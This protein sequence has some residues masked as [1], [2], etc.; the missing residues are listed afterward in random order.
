[1]KLEKFNNKELCKDSIYLHIKTGYRKQLSYTDCIYSIF[2][3]HNETV[4]IWTHLGTSILFMFLFLSNIS[5]NIIANNYLFYA[6]LGFLCSSI[7]HIF[8]CNNIYY[9]I[10]LCIDSTGLFSIIYLSVNSAMS[11][12]LLK[13]VLINYYY[14]YS[15]FYTI[16]IFTAYLFFI[17]KI[18][19][20]NQV[21]HISQSLSVITSICYYYIPLLHLY[22]ICNNQFIIFYNRWNNI[23]F[24]WLFCFFIF[25]LRLPERLI[26][27]KFDYFLNSHNIF[28][29]LVSYCACKHY[30]ILNYI[31]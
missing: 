16:Y 19:E 6:S 9:K 18:I 1:M 7:F 27:Y 20:T 4:N 25:G 2:C 28:H 17:K 3:I 8:L 15:N 21:I 24:M 10:S 13:S 29:M 11:N 31:E 30:N 22:F 26:S 23:F 5:N 12:T 14:Y